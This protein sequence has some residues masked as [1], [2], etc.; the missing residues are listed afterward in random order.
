VDLLFGG[1]TR[2][3]LKEA[4]KSMSLP[5]DAAL[6]I[7]AAVKALAIAI[8]ATVDML[9]V[10][11]VDTSDA[12]VEAFALELGG[13]ARKAIPPSFFELVVDCA[14][15]ILWRPCIGGMG[16]LPKIHCVFILAQVMDVVSTATILRDQSHGCVDAAVI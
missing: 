3:V 9:A 10:A 4:S 5:V 15:G 16:G 2:R 6:A 8:A 13:V 14:T 1:V 7:V 11:V 12:G